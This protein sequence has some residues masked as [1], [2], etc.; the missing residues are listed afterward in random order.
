[1]TTAGTLPLG[2]ALT[3]FGLGLIGSGAFP[4]DAMRG[5]P[6]GTPDG[7]PGQF[8]ARHRWHDNLGAAVFLALPAAAGSGAV[9]LPGTAWR[10]ISAVTAVGLLTGFFAFGTAWENHSPRTGLIQRAIIIPGWAWTAAVFI[11]LATI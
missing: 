5:Y 2:I 4:M 11:Y 7:D 9:V 10:V 6:P 3:V 8:S 1:M